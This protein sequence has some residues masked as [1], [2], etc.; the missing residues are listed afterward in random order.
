LANVAGGNSSAHISDVSRKSLTRA[1]ELK[2][3]YAHAYYNRAMLKKEK[4]DA[5]GA[6]QISNARKS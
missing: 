4:G 3:D 6:A 1:I 2:P 5:A